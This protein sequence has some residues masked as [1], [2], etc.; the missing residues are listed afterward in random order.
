MHGTAS[1]APE[2]SG[3]PADTPPRTPRWSLAGL[4]LVHAIVFAWASATL[5]WQRWTVFAATTAALAA[6]HAATALLALAGSRHR[7]R[8]W[9]VTA[10]VSLAYLALHTFTAVTAGAYIAALYGGLGRG[11]AAGLAAVWGVFVLLTAPLAVWGLAATGGL[12]RRRGLGLAGALVL[13]FGLGMWRATAAA[14]ATPLPHPTG[15]ASPIVSRQGPP[16]TADPAALALALAGELRRAKRP[17]PGDST[18]I[19]LWTRQPAACDG[20][21]D[22]PTALVTYPVRDTA[23]PVKPADKSPRLRGTT[24]CV[25]ADEPAALIPAIAALVADAAAIGPMKIDIVTGRQPLSASLPGPTPLLLRPGLDGVCDGRRC[26][27]P[28]QLVSLGLFVTHTPL[29]FIEDL[30]FGADP[31]ALRRAL[32]RRGETPGDSVDGLDRITTHSFFVDAAGDVRHA[33]RMREVQDRLDADNLGAAALAAERHI[34]A[35][36]DPD[37]RFRY[38]LHPFSGRVTWKGFAVPRQAGTTLALCELGSQDPAVVASAASS[39]KML[40]SLEQQAGDVSGLVYHERPPPPGPRRPASLG[41]TALP[42]IAYLT[43][44]PRTG[45]G[46]DVLIGRLG[47][48]LLAMQRPDGGFHPRYDLDKAAPI[49]GPDPMYAAGQAVYALALLEGLLAAHPDPALPDHATVQAAVARAMT[50]FADDYWGH[51]LYGFF[52]LE[53][54]WHCLAARAALPIH[55]HTG[56]ENFCLDYVDFKRRLIF[57]ERSGV[58][59]DLVGAYGFGNVLPP[60]NTP[61]AGFGEAL[62][63]AMAVRAAQGTTRPEDTRLMQQVLTFLVEQQ[64]TEHNCFACTPDHHVPGGFSES[65]GS[66]DLRI[67][68]TQHAWAALGHGGRALGLLAERSL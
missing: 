28:W 41:D 54:N 36:Q 40:A 57:D 8:A 24:R 10:F 52:F 42:L 45:P 16:G 58:S 39:L 1:S 35:A 19:A 61:T 63:A 51:G 5:P 32:V 55:R 20:P 27:A 68:Y 67:D 12:A 11:V 65:V 59:D 66:P 21:L 30:R 64:W 23:K 37:G 48:F 17:V 13:M 38:I 44:R 56:Y 7:A 6:C 3:A 2:R 50:Y 47:R 62:S 18:K 53:E 60:H 49:P 34:L 46:H 26:L 14:A 43:C 9:R 25:Q 31:Y 15:G 33:P 29:P 4:A 22:R